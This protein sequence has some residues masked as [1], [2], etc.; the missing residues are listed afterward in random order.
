MEKWKNMILPVC[1][2]PKELLCN[3]EVLRLPLGDIIM[4]FRYEM[5]WSFLHPRNIME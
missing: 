1:H 5:V 3:T 4:A 2:I